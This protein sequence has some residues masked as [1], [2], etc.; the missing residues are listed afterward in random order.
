MVRGWGNAT[1]EYHRAVRKIRTPRVRVR[2]WIFTLK[3]GMLMSSSGVCRV[4]WA[5]ATG[6]DGTQPWSAWP[7]SVCSAKGAASTGATKGVQSGALKRLLLG[8]S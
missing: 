2:D 6:E 7:Q 5:E 8:L 1:N 3:R 4:A